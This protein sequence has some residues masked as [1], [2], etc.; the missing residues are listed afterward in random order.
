MTKY[1]TRE[2]WL[3]SAAEYLYNDFIGNLGDM[4]KGHSWAVSCGWP[5]TR[6]QS[7][8]RRR[9]GECWT[10]EA[11]ADKST[12]HIFISPVLDRPAEVLATLLHELIHAICGTVVGHKGPFKRRYT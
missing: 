6:S 2:Q 4:A 3:E 12:Y 11:C 10:H 8:K 1:D 5:S 7:T 9:L